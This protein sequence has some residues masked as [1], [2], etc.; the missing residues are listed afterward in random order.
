[1]IAAFR[2]AKVAPHGRFIPDEVERI[3]YARESSPV[4]WTETGAVAQFDVIPTQ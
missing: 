3:S 4:N 1:M 2:E